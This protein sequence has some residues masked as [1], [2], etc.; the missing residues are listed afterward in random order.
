VEKTR[1]PRLCE[2]SAQDLSQ[3]AGMRKAVEA[4][5]VRPVARQHRG[6]QVKM[7][8]VALVEEALLERRQEEIRFEN[9]SGSGDRD[10][11]AVLDQCN[12]ILRGHEFFH[13]AGS[14]CLDC[15]ASQR[16]RRPIESSLKQMSVIVRTSSATAIGVPR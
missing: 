15:P 4:A 1:M 11:R 2:G 9:R 10:G 16:S 6:K 8:R 3:H 5:I 13:Q 7:L 14:L 12:G